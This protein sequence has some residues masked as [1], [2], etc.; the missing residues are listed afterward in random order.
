[1]S[2]SGDNRGRSEKVR[3]LGDAIRR[4]RTGE[5][6]RTDVVVDLR[7]AER[8]RLELLA[9]ELKAV[10]AEVPAEDE[11]F[12]F[13]VA[14]GTPPRLWIDMTSHVSMGRDHRTYRFLR[15][16]RVG[17][18]IVRESDEL[19]A[20]A[21]TVT[22]Y[23]AERIV[24][25]RRAM[26]GEWVPKR[27]APDPSTPAMRGRA[28]IAAAGGEPAHAGTLDRGSLGWLVA[29]FLG[30]LLVGAVGLLVY[31]WVSAAG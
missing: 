16:T 15:D 23:V 20:I 7:D 12:I 30:G 5:A 28:A 25:K 2:D 10:F 18:T 1:M 4:V 19:S 13:A 8:A 22:E 29:A 26:E 27:T 6:E 3:S 24:E 9:D 14:G 31:V 11:Q 17:R 21:D